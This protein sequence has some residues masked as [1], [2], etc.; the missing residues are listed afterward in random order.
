MTTFLA[1]RTSP[2]HHRCPPAR[3]SNPEDALQLA[4]IAYLDVALPVGA[5]W[6]ATPNGG[7]RNPVTARRLKSLG[8]KAGIPDLFVLHQ[9]QLIGVELKAPPKRLPSGKLSKAKPQ[10]KA[11]QGNMLPMLAQAGCPTLVCQSLEQVEQGLRALGVPLRASNRR[12]LP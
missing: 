11:S 6:W 4:V 2:D 12:I 1:T 10:L 7:H 3:R 8:V 9:G 5:V